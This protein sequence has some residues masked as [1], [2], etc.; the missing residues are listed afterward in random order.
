METQCLATMA[1]ATHD[2][3]IA[4][5]AVQASQASVNHT[6]N[7][8]TGRSPNTYSPYNSNGNATSYFNSSYQ[9][10]KAPSPDAPRIEDVTADS[11]YYCS[12]N[13][14]I[15]S[16]KTMLAVQAKNLP[17]EGEP[18]SD[19]TLKNPDGTPKQKRWYG[20]DGKPVRDRDYNHSGKGIPF[21]HDHEWKDG[22][23]QKEHLPPSPEYQFS[24]EPA[25]GVGII[26]VGGV[27]IGLVL[28]DNITGIGVGDD[29]LL[30]PIAALISKG[31]VMVGV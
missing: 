26:I 24:L 30:G 4:R 3:N 12:T 23:R 8:A 27:A 28:A 18:G 2:P 9:S 6:N 29:F 13:K 10:G 17:P 19:Q 25:I 7:V 20:E 21:P 16:E 22:K 31:I 14:P 11:V 1:N 5:Q 15:V